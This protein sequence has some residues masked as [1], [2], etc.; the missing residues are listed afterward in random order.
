MA[1]IVED[2]SI[3]ANANTFAT[4]AECRAF[5]ADRGLSL[6]VVD[7][8]VEKLLVKAGDFL[9]QLEEKFQ[10]QR[11][12]PSQALPFPRDSLLMFGE[13]FA[14]TIPAILKQGQ[15]R[16]AYDA[17]Q[18]DLQA[19]GSG[20][21]VKKKTVGPLSTEYDDSASN[22]QVNPTAALAIL[23]PLFKRG[24]TLALFRA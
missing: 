21:V 7:S 3:V 22:P 16:L 18:A 1:L 2:G 10:G 8:D 13:D 4:V 9:I 20:R 15:C 19:T 5:A 6:P 11:Q 12:D 24:S 14:G 17:S 23:Q